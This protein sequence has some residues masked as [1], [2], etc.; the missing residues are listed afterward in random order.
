MVHGLPAI[1]G[2]IKLC[3]GC[4]IGKQRR[5]PFPSQ[6]SYRAGESL[7]L[8]QGNICGSIKPATPGG[9]IL[10]LL[11]VKS[12]AAKAIKRI[13]ARAEVEC[14]KKMLMLRTDRGREFTSVSFGKYC[15]DLGM[16][17]KLTT[18]YSPQQ[19]EVVE[20]QN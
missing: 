12:E 2:V 6:G 10:F 3:D 20:P 14:G 18:P 17:R 5:T 9:K 19:H 15:D 1:E 4:L 8:A 7:E 13:Q 11:Q 16:Q